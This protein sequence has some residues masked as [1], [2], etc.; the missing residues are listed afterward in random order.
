MI[1]YKEYKEGKY[2]IVIR[3]EVKYWC[4]KGLIHRENGPAVKAGDSEHWYKHGKLH[5]ED[6]PAQEWFNGEKE[7]FWYLDNKAYSEKEYNIEMRKRKLKVLG[8]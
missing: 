4:Y 7:K 2:D 1:D 5:R 6:G 3:D 8:L